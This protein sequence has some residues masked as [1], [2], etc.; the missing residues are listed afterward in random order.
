MLLRLVR[1]KKEGY[2]YVYNTNM[3][4][5]DLEEATD[6]LVKESTTTTTDKYT[7]QFSG[8]NPGRPGSGW[9]YNY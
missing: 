5:D 4:A 6:S 7:T 9:F 1:K 2:Y 3:D 8:G